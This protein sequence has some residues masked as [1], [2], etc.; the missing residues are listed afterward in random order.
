MAY[1]HHN[2]KIQSCVVEIPW[3]IS[4]LMWV[5]LLSFKHIIK[6]YYDFIYECQYRQF[7]TRKQT[8]S[9]ILSTE[10]I[11]S[12]KLHKKC[13]LLWTRV[14]KVI[15]IIVNNSTKLKYEIAFSSLLS[16]YSIFTLLLWNHS[17]FL[18]FVIAYM[19][20]S[21]WKKIRNMAKPQFL[22]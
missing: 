16:Y 7:N 8:V 4:V 15:N 10:E 13:T 17:V 11:R 19:D 12:C 14:D 1:S 9:V 21:T 5:S 20:N 3:K 18:K 6:E 22:L 2:E